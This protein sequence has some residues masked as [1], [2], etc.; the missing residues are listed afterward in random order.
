MRIYADGV[1]D[2]FHY[3]H[4]RLLRRARESGGEG[5]TLVVGVVS[6]EDAASYKRRPVMRFE[7]RREVVR[8]CRYA[9]EVVAAPLVM[10]EAFLREQRIDRVIHGDD[11]EQADFYAVPRA[12][13]MMLYLPY[14]DS[15]STSDIMARMERRMADTGSTPPATPGGSD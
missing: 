7:E 1:F 3:G 13:G 2:L 12:R 4:V 14:T 6:D 9:D 5:A 8:G 11:S 15:V 10:T